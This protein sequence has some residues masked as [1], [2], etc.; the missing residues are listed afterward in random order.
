VPDIAV[1][2]IFL[3]HGGYK[4]GTKEKLYIRPCRTNKHLGFVLHPLTVSQ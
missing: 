3:V 4:N 1:H 2:S